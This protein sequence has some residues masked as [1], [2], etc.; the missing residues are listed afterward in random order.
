MTSF[1][2]QNTLLKDVIDPHI[3]VPEGHVAEGVASIT[4]MAF[5]CLS[6]DPSSRPT[7]RQISLELTAGGLHCQSPFLK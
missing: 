1:I 5:S 7:M 3:P 4:K 6:A 2:G